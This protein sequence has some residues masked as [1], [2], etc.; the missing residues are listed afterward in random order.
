MINND[1]VSGKPLIQYTDTKANIEALTGLLEGST[2]YATDTNELG[3]Y[4]GSGW[5]W[6]TGGSASAFTDLTDTFA[7]YTG[8]GDEYVKVKADES[9]LETG[10][11]AGGGDVLGPALSTDEHLAV[12]DGTNSKTLKDGGIV[13]AGGGDVLGPETSTDE[14]LAVWDGTD[15]KTLKDG[16]EIPTLSAPPSLL[17]LMNRSFI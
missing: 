9:G 16:G 10:V 7:S 15:S 2:A 1:K 13:P 5:T 11:P 17:V 14:H 12:W 4:D 6:G 3:T 8:L